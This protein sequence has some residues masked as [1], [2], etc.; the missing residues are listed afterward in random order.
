MPS[1]RLHICCRKATGNEVATP[2]TV[3]PAYQTKPNE[4]RRKK[5]P[6]TGDR[7]NV[8]CFLAKRQCVAPVPL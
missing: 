6:V 8:H 4:V 7:E 5:H 1:C 3:R 2:G